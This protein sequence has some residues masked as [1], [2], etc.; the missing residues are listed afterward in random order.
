ME[1]KHPLKNLPSIRSLTNSRQF[2][3]SQANKETRVQGK[4]K[5]I[6]LGVGVGVVSVLL[7]LFATILFVVYTGSYNVAAT[8][9]HNPFVRWALTTT[10]KNAVANGA[11]D[12]EVPEFTDSMIAAGASHFLSTCQHCH[13]GPGVDRKTWAKGLL[14]EPPYLPDVIAE[15]EPNEISWLVKHGLKMTGMPAFGTHHSDEELW[16]ITAFVV[17][18]PGMTAEEYANFQ[19]DRDE[20]DHSAGGHGSEGHGDG[21]T[22]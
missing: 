6:A 10:M 8:E 16:D 20:G 21:H 9:D 1:L 7:I 2:G 18:L 5:Q 4:A 17:Q 13:G 12:L 19:N 11:S 14:P 3:V 22:H 15:W